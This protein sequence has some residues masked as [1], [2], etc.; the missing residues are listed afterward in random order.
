[1]AGTIVTDRIESDASY[2]SSITVASPLVV[3]NT[4]SMTN[5]NITGNVNFDS[6]TLFVDSVGNKVGIGTTSPSRELSIAKAGQTNLSILNTSNSVELRLI[7][8][9]SAAY[10]QTN[11]NHPLWF[12][13][14]NGAVQM[15]IDTSGRV[16]KPFQPA[17]IAVMT[18]GGSN[19]YGGNIIYPSAVLNVG[20]HYSTGTGRF[21][22]PVAGRYYFAF[23]C[24]PA[25]A[26]VE[27]INATYP[28]RIHFSKNGSIYPTG[29]WHALRHTDP[30]LSIG[31]TMMID[32]AAG[33]YVNIYTSEQ[34]VNDDSAYNGFW[35][36]FLG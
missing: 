10:V 13:T 2:A 8:E 22:A 12:A 17:F 33:D 3:S 35:G 16:T 29:N 26:G 21:T 23:Q 25:S 28:L 5:G 11:T 31:S 36:Y 18:G 34:R 32:L 20:S 7:A 24:I 19:S 14:N 15:A 4:I 27:P 6:G 9:S 1:M 30:N